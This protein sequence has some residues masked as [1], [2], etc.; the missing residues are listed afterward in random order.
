MI[1]LFINVNEKWKLGNFVLGKHNTKEF[2]QLFLNIRDYNYSVFRQGGKILFW[3]HF[4]VY[5]YHK[6]KHLST[7]LRKLN[8]ELETY[9]TDFRP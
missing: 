4:H 6:H 1:Y 7:F 5:L 8:V 2:Q 9:Y 3:K